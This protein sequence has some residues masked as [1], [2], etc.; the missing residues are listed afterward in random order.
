MKRI[1]KIGITV[2]II[3][4]TLAAITVYIRSYTRT[5]NGA[6]ERTTE[7]YIAILTD[8]KEDFEYVAR[9]MQQWDEGS[10]SFNKSFGKPLAFDKAIIENDEIKS[11]FLSNKDFYNSLHNLYELDEIWEIIIEE[12]AIVFYYSKPPQGYHDCGVG[13]GENIERRNA[14]PIDENRVYQIEAGI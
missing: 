9:T 1:N 8:N 3:I 5:Y 7:E 6:F 10:I 14:S 12:D 13:Y 4:I 2:Y 11:E